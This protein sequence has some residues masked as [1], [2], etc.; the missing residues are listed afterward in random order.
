MPFLVPEVSL[1]CSR[2]PN[3]GHYPEPDKSSILPPFLRLG[4]PNGLFPPGS[5]TTVLYAFLITSTHA[6]FP[7]HPILLYFIALIIFCEELLHLRGHFVYTC[8]LIFPQILFYFSFCGLCYVV[9]SVSGEIQL[10]V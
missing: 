6:T 8:Y 10:K 3:T 4:H 7:V 5:P 1:P 2:E 9:R